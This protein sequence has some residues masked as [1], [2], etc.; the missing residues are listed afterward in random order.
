M[1]SSANRNRAC[2]PTVNSEPNSVTN[3][4]SPGRSFLLRISFH[5]A[6]M[7]ASSGLRS[8]S[9]ALATIAAM[10]PCANTSGAAFTGSPTSDNSSSE[11]APSFCRASEFSCR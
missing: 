4:R 5:L 3:I 6:S 9:V 8:S 2:W 11:A 10:R 1:S 7:R